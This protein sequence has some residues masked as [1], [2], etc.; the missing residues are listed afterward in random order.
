MLNRLVAYLSNPG[1]THVVFDVVAR[2]YEVITGQAR[3][4]ASARR[5]ARWLPDTAGCRVLDLG[6]GPANSSLAILDARP[7]ARVVALDRAP[8]MVRLA[9]R[10][11]GQRPNLAVILG[12]ASALPFGPETFDL[13]T[14]HSFLYLVPQRERVLAEARRVLRVDGHV[15]FLEPAAGRVTAGAWARLARGGARFLTSMVGWRLFSGLHGRWTPESLRATLEGAGFSGV[16]TEPSFEGLGLLA[17]GRRDA[18]PD[19]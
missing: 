6:A 19:A 2:G 14:G 12:D 10:A 18:L 5:F 3:W 8:A 1:E 17:A 16:V 15:A 11:T 13:A 9:R 7:D 4:D